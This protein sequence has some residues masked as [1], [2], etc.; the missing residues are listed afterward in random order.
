[1]EAS[2]GPSSDEDDADGITVVA[3][4][5]DD[6]DNDYN[7]QHGGTGAQAEE[8]AKD[9]GGS[10][11][12]ASGHP[13]AAAA[14][15][16]PVVAAVAARAPDPNTEA[17]SAA[18]AEEP[19]GSSGG[20]GLAWRDAERRTLC[21]A[22][23]II[24]QDAIFGTDRTGRASRTAV[25]A[26]HRWRMSRVA[27]QSSDGVI[28][29]GPYRISTAVT[30]DM[31]D[32]NT[33]YVQRLASSFAA[34][35]RPNLTGKMTASQTEAAAAT[36]FEKRNMYDAVRGYEEK[37][38][39]AAALHVEFASTWMGSWRVLQ[40][41]DKFSGAGGAAGG[42][43]RT[44]RKMPR[45]AASGGAVRYNTRSTRTRLSIPRGKMDR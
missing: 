43:R 21:R 13:L 24:A 4:T 16:A 15:V 40:V 2:R 1:M 7:M 20:R 11:A 36:H 22:Y 18:S 9:T 25:A 3:R 37:M 10:P 14:S 35:D 39:E 42:R 28:L 6:D 17:A 29:H 12:A 8:P 19:S 38:K 34:V 30:K 5:D 27:P 41:M 23:R 31:R 45:S 44:G 26:E 33:Q 32:H